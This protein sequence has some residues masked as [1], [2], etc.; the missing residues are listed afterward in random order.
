MSTQP[1]FPDF[2]EVTLKRAVDVEGVRLPAGAHGVVM[3]GYADGQ[4]Y[5]VEFEHPRHVVV[6]LEG[7]DLAA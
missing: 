5:E 3:A 1:T 2:T 7:E 4:A 6:T